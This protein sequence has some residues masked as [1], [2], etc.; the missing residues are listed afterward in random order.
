MEKGTFVACV[1]FFHFRPFQIRFA[2]VFN[3]FYHVPCLQDSH[4]L[5][6]LF[7][8]L[9]DLLFLFVPKSSHKF[10]T[11]FLCVRLKLCVKIVFFYFCFNFFKQ[12]QT[13]SD[14]KLMSEKRTESRK[15]QSTKK[16]YTKKEQQHKNLLA[17]AACF[18]FVMTLCDRLVA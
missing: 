2:C 15:K 8:N 4:F 3:L 13:N 7:I 6:D 5:F 14:S 18:D 12:R 17:A 16:V 10:W 9:F 11:I 1:F